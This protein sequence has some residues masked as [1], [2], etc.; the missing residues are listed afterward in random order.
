MKDGA[1]NMVEGFVAR[2]VRGPGQCGDS[3][4]L[5]CCISSVACPEC[6]EICRERGD[7]SEYIEKMWRLDDQS[8][9]LRKKRKEAEG[10]RT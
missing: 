2:P 10:S 7:S 4:E 1:R 5:T 8:T 6:R 9:A 3:G